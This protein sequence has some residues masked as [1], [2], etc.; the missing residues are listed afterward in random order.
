MNEDHD[1]HIK[2]DLDLTIDVL[3]DMSPDMLERVRT[4]AEFLKFEGDKK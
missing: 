1:I 4:Y 2:S 3:R